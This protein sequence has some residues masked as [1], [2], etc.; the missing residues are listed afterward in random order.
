VSNSVKLRLPA[1]RQAQP[2]DPL[3][4]QHL[5]IGTTG[6][7]HPRPS[8]LASSPVPG[9]HILLVDDHIDTLDI[10]SRLL[11]SLGYAAQNAS[12]VREAIEQAAS[13]N[14]D[15][16]ITDLTLPDGNGADL[17]KQICSARSIPAIAL[18]GYNPDDDATETHFA[19]RL[20]K[21]VDFQKLK[22]TIQKLL[23]D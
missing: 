5:S 14:F 21:P 7:R 11:R 2:K 12:C 13:T 15:L 6:I 3:L 18:S 16:L 22:E 20:V 19:A 23:P 4:I 8:P 9:Q 17:A 10:L 1:P